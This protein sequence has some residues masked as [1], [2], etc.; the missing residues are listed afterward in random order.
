MSRVRILRAGLCSTV[1]D[2]G[3]RHLGYL[4]IPISGAMDLLSHELANRLVGNP[5]GAATV[6]MTL[7]GDEME[8]VDDTL[9]AITG[10]D[11]QPVISHG[12][13]FP[14]TVAQ[15]CPI[16]VRSGGRIRFQAA[17]RGCRCYVAIAGGVDVPVVLGSRSTLLRAAFGG[18]SGRMLITGDELPI[19]DAF[20]SSALLVKRLMRDA[21][22]ALPVLQPTWFVRPEELPNSNIATLRMIPGSHTSLLTEAVRENF[23]DISFVVSAQSDRMGFR[24]TGHR[25][26]LTEHEELQS[27]GVT[28]GTIQLPSDG[29]PILLMADCAPTGGYPRV[30][31]VISAD[32]GLAAQLQPGQP[33][34]FVTVSM[35]QAQLLFRQQRHRLDKSILGMELIEDRS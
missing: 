11:M 35:E 20:E 5:G 1:Q 30:G 17:R 26:T 21:R 13:D 33:V 24:L 29:N 8:F 15:H 7:T 14:Q 19:G 22:P 34:R 9:I 18:H 2:R 23:Q 3:R 28:P 12:Q 25:L 10:A 4:G 16:V 27:E 6:E 31:H 32:L